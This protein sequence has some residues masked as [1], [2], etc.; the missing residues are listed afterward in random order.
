MRA[1]F[2]IAFHPWK[3]ASPPES[4]RA[5]SFGGKKLPHTA[6]ATKATAQIPA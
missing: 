2:T 6:R 4:S 3:T 1:S 5:R